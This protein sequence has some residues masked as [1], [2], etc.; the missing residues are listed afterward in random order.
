MIAL[1]LVLYVGLVDRPGDAVR[2]D[3]AADRLVSSRCSAA[4]LIDRRRRDARERHRTT[5]KAPR[6]PMTAPRDDMPPDRNLALELVRVTEA[7]AL[8]AARLRRHGRQGGGRPGRRGRHA[9]RAAHDPHGRRRRD[10]RGREGR[11]ADARQ[12][13][14]R[15]R[16]HA[17]ARR[18][19][20]RPARGHAAGR[21]G[22]PE[23][24][25]GDRA[26]RARHDVRPRPG[27][28]H[29]EDGRRA[30]SSSTCSTS[31]ARSARPSS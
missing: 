6:S 3:L 18:H 12:R 14:G 13:R 31:T 27:L 19:R 1:V 5:T 16:R 9:R 22:P 15:R 30:T 21:P 8:Q 28:L 2:A 10:R 26:V 11:G 17:A 7:A 20:R 24:A 4:L 25:V 23:R 29:G